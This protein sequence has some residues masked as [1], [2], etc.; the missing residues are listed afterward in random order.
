M[1]FV[2]KIKN[3]FGIIAKR[4]N[5]SFLMFMRLEELRKQDFNFKTI[6]HLDF[7]LVNLIFIFH[8]LRLYY[9]FM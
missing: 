3:D 1:I 4:E 5:G 7:E 9:Y 2:K 6:F 8:K